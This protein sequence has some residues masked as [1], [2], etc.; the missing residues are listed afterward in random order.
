MYNLNMGGSPYH[1]H[2]N[3]DDDCQRIDG[4]KTRHY[5]PSSERCDPSLEPNLR[6]P[7]EDL[8]SPRIVHQHPQ[9]LASVSIQSGCSRF[10]GFIAIYEYFMMLFDQPIKNYNENYEQ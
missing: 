8:F 10:H 5:G 1:N 2:N 3:E 4:I 9:F 7:A 6:Q